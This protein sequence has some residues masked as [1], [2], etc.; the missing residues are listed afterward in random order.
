M[1]SLFGTKRTFV[2]LG[3]GAKEAGLRINKQKTKIMAQTRKLMPAR[4]NIIVDE[5]DLKNTTLLKER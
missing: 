2:K 4:V 3:N 1:R 5:Y